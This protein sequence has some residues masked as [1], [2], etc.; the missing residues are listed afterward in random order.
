M[1]RRASHPH[2]VIAS[3]LSL[4]LVVVTA[5]PASAGEPKRVRNAED[6]AYKLV[7]CLRTGGK[8]TTGGKC[9][10]YGTGKYSSK[11]VAFKRSK[12]ISGNVAWPWAKRTVKANIC[13]HTLAGS[14][15]DKRFRSAGLGW[16]A[17][18]ENIGCSWGWTTKRMVKTSGGEGG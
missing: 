13:G 15:V 4:L 17:N 12:R 6:L 3:L 7:N 14:T 10:G 11:R 8:V 9:K 5:A 16:A 18:G 1:T 2:L